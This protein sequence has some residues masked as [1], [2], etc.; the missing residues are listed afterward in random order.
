MAVTRSRRGPAA[1]SL[2][3]GL[4]RGMV[5]VATGLVVLGVTAYGFLVISA[6]A[7]GP[8]RYAPL[9]V[10]WA[11][12]FLI[13]PGLFVPLEQELTRAIAAQEA[14][15]AGFAGLL[16]KA[17]L[18]G[19]GAVAVLVVAT[20]I[21]GR[22]LVPR[23]F[24]D[25]PLLLAGLV[26]SV[27]GYFAEHL[28]R[29]VLSG[30][31]RFRPYGTI[32]GVEGA[33]RLAGAAV[34]AAMGVSTPGLYGL[35]LGAAP[36]VATAVGVRGHALVP[37]HRADNPEPA[38]PSL[39]NALGWLLAAS[40][41][42]QLLVNGAPVA[43]KALATARERA[44]VGRFMA[45]LIVARVPLFL[46]SAVQASALPGLSRLAAAG[47]HDEFKGRLR[48][49]LG[50]VG[51]FGVAG[52]TGAAIVGPR[53][54]QVLFGHQFRLGRG[55]LVYLAAASAG[56]ML[57]MTVAQALIALCAQARV[58]LGWLAGFAT[59][60]LV[61][62]ISPGLLQRAERGLLAGSLVA[63]AAMGAALAAG[64]QHQPPGAVLASPEPGCLPPPIP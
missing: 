31:G 28:V 21:A 7:L 23:L 3:G 42:A 16:R 33:V 54:V 5:P 20:T 59:F 2:L 61:V 22:W 26:L 52:V 40:V 35:V 17:A 1:L 56:Y 30:T 58:A 63:L 18:A 60:V 8:E 14:T 43:V 13:G 41:F 19:G 64:M 45:G 44:V 12:V 53:V 48:Q 4:P 15:G 6:R 49:L 11:L 27:A 57:A 46:F 10:L 29:G 51:G 25:Q 9:S 39:T 55:D 24:D 32:L 50:V 36:L 38:G 34:L 62:A 47:R 37:H